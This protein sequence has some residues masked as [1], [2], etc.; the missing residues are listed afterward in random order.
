MVEMAG[1][2]HLGYDLVVRG[3]TCVTPGGRAVA[4]VAI[5]GGRIAAI[6]AIAAGAGHATLDARGL[7]VLPGVIDAQ[8]HFREPGLETKEDLA[9]G[10]TAAVLGGVTAVL[11]MPNTDPPTTTAAALADKLARLDKR[12]RCH[13]GFLVGATADNARDL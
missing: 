4:D 11:E 13:V 8:V 10:T 3:G 1:D 5:R 7:H 9:T 2:D 6:G 12:A